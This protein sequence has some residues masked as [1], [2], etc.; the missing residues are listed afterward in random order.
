M[1]QRLSKG[2]C[3][4]HPAW[5]SEQSF[6]LG[7]IVCI[8]WKAIRAQRDWITRPVRRQGDLS[9]ARSFSKCCVPLLPSKLSVTVTESKSLKHRVEWNARLIGTYACTHR[10]AIGKYWPNV[11]RNILQVW[12]MTQCL[13]K[14]HAVFW[15]VAAIEGRGT[16]YNE[17]R[18]VL[19]ARTCVNP[20]FS[21]SIHP[22]IPPSNTSKVPLRKQ[23]H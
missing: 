18:R 4:Y 3:M 9:P 13:A 2:L 8:L 20:V 22:S 6:D 12:I 19:R 11:L 10:C 17:V 23:T 14:R 5:I 7:F 1:R 21:S 16:K 15:T